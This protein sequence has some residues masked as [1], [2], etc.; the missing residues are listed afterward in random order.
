VRRVRSMAEDMVTREGVALAVF[1]D[2]TNA[3]DTIPW[4]RIVEGPPIL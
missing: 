2:V 1:L 3:F 4:A